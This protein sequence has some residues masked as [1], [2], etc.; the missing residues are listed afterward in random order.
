VK[1]SVK[2]AVNYVGAFE[3]AVV[4]LARLEENIDGVVCGHIH[5]AAIRTIGPLAYYNSGDWVESFTALVEEHDGEIRLLDF[6]PQKQPARALR[7]P[8]SSLA[9]SSAA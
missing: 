1:R 4:R 7:Q 5:T 8:E 2:N 9:T 6:S 3:D